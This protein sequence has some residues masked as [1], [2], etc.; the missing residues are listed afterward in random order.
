MPPG[1]LASLA[2]L[3]GAKRMKMRQP[4]LGDAVQC[5]FP[6]EGGGLGW[7]KGAVSWVEPGGGHFRV[8][9]NGE[10]YP[11]AVITNMIG[12]KS[13]RFVQAV[14]AASLPGVPRPQKQRMC[15]GC[16]LKGSSYGLASEDKRR[17]CAGCGAAVEGAVSLKKQRMCE[18]CGLK[19]PCHGLASEGKRRWCA[20]CGAAEGAVNLQTQKQNLRVAA[21]CAAAA[22]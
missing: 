18:G 5:W 10:E 1:V 15:E 4:S 14:A 3:P 20:G 19:Q 13:W 8:T 7:E 2:G 11:T 6:E 21:E 17:W 22:T 16:G 12:D 9:Y